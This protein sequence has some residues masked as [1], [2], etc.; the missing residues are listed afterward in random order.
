L[1]VMTIVVVSEMYGLTSLRTFAIPMAFGLIS[2]GISSVFISGP[3]W[4]L[5]KRFRAKNA[6]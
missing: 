5:W 3:V 2:G 4:V 1:A 6:K